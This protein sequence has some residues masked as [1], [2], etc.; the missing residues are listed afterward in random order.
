MLV[1]FDVILC[2]G[3]VAILFVFFGL[4]CFVIVFGLLVIRLVVRCLFVYC[5]LL[6]YLRFD[7][8]CIGGL[9]SG[10]FGVCYLFW[11]AYLFCVLVCIC[12][13]DGLGLFALMLVFVC[14]RCGCLMICLDVCARCRF[15]WIDV[16]LLFCYF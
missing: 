7:L 10:W 15:L 4:L 6:C 1:V 13:F 12:C 11:F 14:L 2:L 8:R 3:F 9:F 5:E 16:V